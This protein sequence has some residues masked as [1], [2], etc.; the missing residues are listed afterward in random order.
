MTDVSTAGA[1]LEAVLRQENA[2]LKQLDIAK[3]SLLLQEKLAAARGLNAAP[4]LSRTPEATAM[5][6]RLRDLAHENR[7][8]LERAILAQ[9]RVVELVARAAR[10]AAQANG[11]YG[12]KGAPAWDTGAFAMGTHA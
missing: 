11:G 2:A 12:A 1:R 4:T 10:G 7:R 3:A 9:S 5:A 6:L 8:L